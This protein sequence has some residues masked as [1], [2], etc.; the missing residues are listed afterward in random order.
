MNVLSKTKLIYEGIYTY[1]NEKKKNKLIWKQEK[2]SKLK[3]KKKKCYMY[4]LLMCNKFYINCLLHETST[5]IRDA[6]KYLY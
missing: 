1:E 5:F 2:N 4:S 6:N 3:L